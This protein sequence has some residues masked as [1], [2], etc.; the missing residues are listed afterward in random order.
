MTKTYDD[1]DLDQHDKYELLL[2]AAD[3]EVEL[4]PKAF[5]ELPRTVVCMDERARVAGPVIGLAGSGILATDEQRARFVAK[6]EAA[7]IDQAALQV[8]HH[9]S[10][11]AAGLFV[12]ANPHLETTPAVAAERAA[13]ELKTATASE[14][15]VTKIGWS[16]D[17]HHEAVGHPDHHHAR[18]IYID[19]TGRFDPDVAGLP[20][21]FLISA[22]YSPDDEYLQR[23]VTLAQDIA[24][25]PHGRG[26]KYF[27]EHSPLL[28]VIVSDQPES[29]E[30]AL[31]NSLHRRPDITRILYVKPPK[32]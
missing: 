16:D 27:R 3:G 7:G 28:L 12:E 18:V 32:N 30:L 9:E 19:F 17:S 14:V 10:C 21:G 11:G 4:S 24:A 15:E 29:A 25:G 31:G 26:E 8:T 5:A 20:D 23:E 1:Y 22:A 6:L 2:T 13:R